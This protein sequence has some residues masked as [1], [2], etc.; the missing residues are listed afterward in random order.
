[1]FARSAG[2]EMTHVPYKGT[3]PA[4][5]AIAAGEVAAITTVTSDIGTL[6]KA[7]KARLL[8]TA[9][10]KRASAFPQVPTFRES[11]Y[12]LEGEGWYA[13]FAPAKTPRAAIDR[14]PRRRSPP[15]AGRRSSS[16]SR[17]WDSIR[18]GSGRPSWPRS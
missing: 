6:V 15:C 10:A 12:D 13:L 16:G 14:C 3:A 2:I 5:Q 4:M 18:R 9:G 1:M 17:T 8:A 7:G 11:G